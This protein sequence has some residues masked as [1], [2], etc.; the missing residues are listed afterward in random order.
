[1]S[2]SKANRK[3]VLDSIRAA[4]GANA[5]D[6]WREVNVRHRLVT[7][8]SGTI[9]ARCLGNRD[10]CLALF[11]GML[12]NQ[13]ADVTRVRDPEGVVKAIATYLAKHELPTELRLSEEPVLV[14]LPWLLAPM[15]KQTYGEPSAEDKIGLS[16]AIAG[17][18]ETGTLFLVSGA[19]NPTSLNFLPETHIVMVDEGDIVGC[20]EE[21]WGRLRALYGEGTLPRTVNWISGPSRTADIEQTIVRGA[22]GP[23]RLFVVILDERGP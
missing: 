4:L 2:G 10:A 20:Y 7:H 13:G 14:T 15:L 6:M 9:P 16:R 22:H 18:A 12:V 21:A 17:V 23:K 11:S 5:P 19:G 1:V 8:P 3:T